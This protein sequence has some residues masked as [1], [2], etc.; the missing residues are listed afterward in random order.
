MTAIANQLADVAERH[1]LTVAVA[2]S[3]TAGNLAA[4]LGAAPNSAAWFRGAV[5]AYAKEVKQRVLDV[6]DVPVVSET[7]ATAMAEDVRILMDADIAVATTG[8]GG[9]GPQGG[10]P[11][12]SVWFCTVS[13]AD[14]RT[15]HRQFDGDPAEILDQSIQYAIELLLS[16]ARTI[17]DNAR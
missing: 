11:A 16:M 14:G 13:C 1:S 6:P 9:P 8:V 17:I 2:E 15:I 3:L 7:A 4:A 12:G 5:I 10:E